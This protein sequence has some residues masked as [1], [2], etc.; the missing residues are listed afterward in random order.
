[1]TLQYGYSDFEI[2]LTIHRSNNITST[3]FSFLSAGLILLLAS[4]QK[5]KD[6][7][8]LY[9]RGSLVLADRNLK[10]V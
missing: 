4:F 9:Q 8:K 10:S 2:Y 6:I 1:M 7:S 3:A 5:L